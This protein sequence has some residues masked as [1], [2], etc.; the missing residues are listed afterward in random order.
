MGEHNVKA[1]NKISRSELYLNEFGDTSGVA[2]DYRTGLREL[3]SSL[4]D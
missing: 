4:L 3:V 2:V 1:Q